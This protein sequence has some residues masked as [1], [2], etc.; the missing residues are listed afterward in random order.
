MYCTTLYN[1]FYSS[2]SGQ[3]L[4][5]E[6]KAA[7]L[8]MHSFSEKAAAT[9]ITSTWQLKDKLEVAK[10]AKRILQTKGGFAATIY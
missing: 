8:C 3:M 1:S 7:Q 2:N 6:L 10:E 5:S 4:S 9:M